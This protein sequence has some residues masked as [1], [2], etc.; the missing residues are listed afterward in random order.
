MESL[1][2]LMCRMK[3][4]PAAERLVLPIASNGVKTLERSV[5]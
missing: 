4:G 1:Q 2:Q 5:D 3:L